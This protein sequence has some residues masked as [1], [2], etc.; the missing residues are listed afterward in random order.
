[1]MLR[2]YI[3]EVVGECRSYLRVQLGAMGNYQHYELK[4]IK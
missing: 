2:K 3:F 4:D 1:M